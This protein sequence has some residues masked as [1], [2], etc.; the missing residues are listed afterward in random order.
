MSAAAWLA[1]VLDAGSWRSWDEPAPARAAEPEYRAALERARE[2]SGADEAVLTGR[3]TIGGRPVA[4]IVSEFA[5]LGGSIGEAAALRI[6]A[7]FDRATRE[8]LPV[9]AAPASGGTRMQEGTAAFLRML[10]VSRAVLRHRASRLPYL[11]HLRNPTTGGVLASWASLGDDT[12]AEPGAL[13]G[14]LGPRVVA[15]LGGDVPAEV[16]RAE[17]LLRHGLV[18]AVA[19]AHGFRE[20]AE[21]LLGLLGLLWASAEEVEE[22]LCDP[23]SPVAPG[24]SW[25]AVLA[26][27]DERRPRLPEL[28]A[29]L[30]AFLPRRGGPS[31]LV[32]GFARLAGHTVLLIG[33]DGS[34]GRRTTVGDLAAA[35]EA[36]ALAERLGLPVVTIVDTPGTELSAAAETAGMAQSVAATIAAAEALT[37]PSAT[38]LLGEGAGAA[39]LSL[40]GTDLIVAAEDAWLAPL[41]PE[42]AAAL[43]FGDPA[44]AQRVSELQRIGSASLLA[45]GLLTGA[46]VEG[47][48]RLAVAGGG[49]AAALARALLRLAGAGALVPTTS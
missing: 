9:V 48:P 38:L 41:P 17:H 49:T 40:C 18:D 45:D 28:I 20:R 39:A 44:E 36:F 34:H 8:G 43:T 3:G 26:S 6:V 2:R 25:P 27:R 4:A 32:T 12:V 23:P 30:P 14:L 31:A 21:R 16:Q 33:Q 46:V 24:A 15:A 1:A 19:D 35:R 11:V 10:D 13:I 22:P 47:V 7:A 29:A 5:F 37:V 42:G